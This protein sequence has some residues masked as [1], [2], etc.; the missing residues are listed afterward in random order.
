MRDEKE[1]MKLKES[2]QGYMGRFGR[3]KGKGK[4]R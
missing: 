2:N 4:V 3:R 1:Y